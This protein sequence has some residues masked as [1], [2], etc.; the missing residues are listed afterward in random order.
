VLTSGKMVLLDKLL[1]RLK[2]TGHRFAPR[3]LAS[4]AFLHNMASIKAEYFF[5]HWYLLAMYLITPQHMR[6][7]SPQSADL[8]PNG[9]GLGHRVG[10]HAAE[11]HPAPA[12]GRLHT[13]AGPPPGGVQHISAALPL[14]S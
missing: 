14:G 8:Q 12:V 9:A 1:T 4:S 10:L 3:I 11:G 5:L 7:T 6:L 2:E 13:R